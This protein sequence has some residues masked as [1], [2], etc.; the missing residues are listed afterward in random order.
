MLCYIEKLC[1]IQAT[2]LPSRIEK[3]KEILDDLLEG[4]EGFFSRN[5]DSIE[6]ST[7]ILQV[8]LPIISKNRQLQHIAEEYVEKIRSM[9]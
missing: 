1:S 2:E 4:K 6:G 9:K 5:V 7:F 3:L 8:V